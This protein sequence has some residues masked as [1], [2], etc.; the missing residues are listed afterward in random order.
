MNKSKKSTKPSKSTSQPKDSSEPISTKSGTGSLPTPYQ[1]MIHLSRY[2][3]WDYEKKRRE[4]WPE[5]VDRYIKFFD[6][7][8]AKMHNYKVPEETKERV[9]DAILNLE[10]M[11]SMRCLMTAGPAL[12]KENVAGYNCAYLH[13]DNPNAFDEMLYVLMNGTGVGYSVEQ[14]HIEK[15][16]NVPNTLY[17]TDTTIHVADSKLGWSKA[18]RELLALLWTG[19]IPKWDVSQVRPKGS[20]LKTFGGRASG[21]EPLT[22][23]FE[24][25]VKTF[26]K[27]GG[28]K[29]SAID[30]HD[31][32]CMIGDIVVVGGVRRSALISL[33]DLGDAEMRS[34]KS[35]E[36]WNSTPY[37]RLANN[38][39]NYRVKPDPGTFMAEWKSLYDSKSGERGIFS[40]AAAKSQVERNA[41]GRKA[42]DDFGCNPCSEIILR[43]QQFCNLSEVVCR[44]GDD[45]ETLKKKVAVASIIGTWQSTLTNFNYLG[46]KWRQNCEEERLLGVSMTGIMD[47]AITENLHHRDFA[48]NLKHLKGVARDTNERVARE[49]GIQPSAAITCVKPSG[50]VSQLVDSASGIHP[51][52]S[53]YYIRTVRM[54]NTDPLCQFMIDQGMPYEPEVLSPKDVTVFSF[55]MK[56]PEGSLTRNEVT[57]EE[58]LELW[59]EYQRH[60][61]EHKASITVN[62]NEDEWLRIGSWVYDHFDEMAGV[63]FLPT[64]NNTYQQAPYQDCDGETYDA[65]LSSLP[66][67]QWKKLADYEKADYTTASQ[68]FACVGNSCEVV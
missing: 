54:D 37:R 29:L 18:L 6:G 21:P 34:A 67:I 55:P 46:Y 39:A 20:V 33:S 17:E 61:C 12:E 30:C 3:R 40:S 41:P 28:R 19:H 8:L 26:K 53:E 22:R 24:F 43:S 32:C 31:I 63:S 64:D 49:I 60:W 36:W 13:I 57:G 23:L 16:P 58:Q 51:R 56:S 59:L 10:V 5:T 44:T 50:T 14:R 7:H 15:L 45:M 38:S 4:T 47:C 9:R 1:S 42:L 25:L 62:V 48:A 11:P 52:H 68:E 66:I 35:G 27:S 2:S 65:V